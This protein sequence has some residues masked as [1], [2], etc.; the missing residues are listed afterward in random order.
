MFSI[1][2]NNF[3]KTAIE[4][5]DPTRIRTSIKKSSTPFDCDKQSSS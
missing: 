1:S 5:N 4:T 3:N 2:F